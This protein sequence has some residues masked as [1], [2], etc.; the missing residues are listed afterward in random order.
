MGRNLSVSITMRCL[1][2]DPSPIPVKETVT[3]RIV[4]NMCVLHMMDSDY[5]FITLIFAVAKVG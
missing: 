2:K 5:D 1:R 3:L 4:K